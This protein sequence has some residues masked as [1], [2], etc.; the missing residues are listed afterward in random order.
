MVNHAVQVKTCS[1]LNTDT[2]LTALRRF[3][4]RGSQPQL[5]YSE[6]EKTFSGAFEKVNKNF[7]ELEKKEST[8][9]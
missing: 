2:L 5:L 8:Y 6:N 4:S 3:C 7:E 1:D 9:F